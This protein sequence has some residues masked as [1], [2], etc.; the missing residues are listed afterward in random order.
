[1]KRNKHRPVINYDYIPV[2]P[3]EL[4]IRLSFSGSKCTPK[5]SSIQNKAL[6][7]SLNSFNL[8]IKIVRSSETS[9]NILRIQMAENSTLH[10][11][12]R[13]KLNSSEAVSRC[14]A[15][16]DFLVLGLMLCCD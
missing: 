7:G 9:V 4:A 5:T 8:K 3:T 15:S 14:T 10:C 16:I 11:H 6:L 1:M 2:V 13:E 12:Y